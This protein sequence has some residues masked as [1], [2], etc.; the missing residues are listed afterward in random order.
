MSLR[1]TGA[2]QLPEDP[3]EA[4]KVLYASLLEHLAMLDQINRS[5]FEVSYKAPAKPRTADIA[6]ADGS[7]WNPGAGEGL[8]CYYGGI[9]NKL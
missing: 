7:S 4:V 1:L 8:Y 2:P 6:F 3:K 9:W 5:L